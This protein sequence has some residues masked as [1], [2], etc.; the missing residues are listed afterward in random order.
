MKKQKIKKISIV[1]VLV[2]SLAIN[3]LTASIVGLYSIVAFLE[4]Y[5][6]NLVFYKGQRINNVIVNEFGSQHYF[7]TED[8]V[9]WDGDFVFQGHNKDMTDWANNHRDA[10]FHYYRGASP[11]LLLEEKVKDIC[12]TD[13][14]INNHS[15][16]SLILTESGD[17]Y[18]QDWLEVEKIDD[19]ISSVCY[20]SEINTF[21]YIDNEERLFSCNQNMEKT[22]LTDGVKAVQACI[23]RVLILNGSGDLCELD[24]ETESIS[25]PLFTNVE[26]FEADD[27]SK[28]IKRINE[29][30][31]SYKDLDA[32]ESLLI[33]VLDKQGKLFAKGAY[34]SQSAFTFVKENYLHTY[35]DWECIGENVSNFSL[36]STGT[37]MLLNDGSATYHGYE[38]GTGY[39]DDE[40]YVI[41]GTKTLVSDG[42]VMVGC[43]RRTVW[44]ISEH[45]IM[46][47]GRNDIFDTGEVHYSHKHRI[48]TGGP[49]VIERAY[50]ERLN[51]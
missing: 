11:V 16:H 31:K 22:F 25:E 44:V 33:N 35:D 27:A 18:T 4:S 12:L 17:L 51:R 47:W 48:F 15:C 2:I 32:E 29:K 45:V 26:K 14:P 42:A 8:A 39:N 19:N 38:E 9:Y 21:Y 36:S 24:L 41:F 43:S 13:G 5:T 3:F 46:F 50:S 40:N 6:H 7:V 30:W 34:N 20:D 10:N 28:R 37:M 49:I 23:G 1:I